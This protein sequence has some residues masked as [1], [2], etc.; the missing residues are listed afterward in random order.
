MVAFVAAIGIVVH[1]LLRFAWNGSARAQEVP[2]YVAL[3]LGGTTLVVN[4]SRK[5]WAM[6]FGSDFLAGVSIITAVVLQNYL[7]ATIVVLML[8]GGTALEEFAAGRASHVLDALA[9]RMPNVAHRKSEDGVAEV[10]LSELRVGD[11]LV[12]LPHEICPV[13]GV[14]IEGQGSMNEAYLTGEPFEVGK[15]PGALVLSG[16]LNGESL[17]TIRAERL[18]TDSRYARIMRVMEET[19]QRR[20]RLRRLGDLLG[21]WYTPL[22]LGIAVLA[23]TLSGEV[24][25]PAADCDTRDGDRSGFPFRS[26]GN[27]HQESSRARKDRFQQ[28]FRF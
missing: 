9:K 19:Q 1:L 8:S 7:V 6:E 10:A 13:D 20:P 11:T 12:V 18:P 26:A 21:A 2:L 16:A 3:V 24:D 28:D 17:L 25:L 23:W 27:H 15:A 4:L 14:V 5:L 22:A